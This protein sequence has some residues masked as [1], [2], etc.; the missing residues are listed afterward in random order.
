MNAAALELP[1]GLQNLVESRLDAIERALLQGNTP[2]AERRSILDDIETQI[3]EMLSAEAQGHEP[4]RADLLRV[5][6]RLDPPE[7]FAGEHIESARFAQTIR[8]SAP[9]VSIARS[10]SRTGYSAMGYSATGILACVGGL[11]T[12]T[13]G[14]PLCAFSM[15][16]S[17]SEITVVV[18]G[19]FL[20]LTGMPSMVLGI[21]YAIALH[22][23]QGRLRGLTCAAIGISAFP[24]S[25]IG[26]LGG[27]LAVQMESEI[28]ILGGGVI[29]CVL[30]VVGAIHLT[31]RSLELL[32]PRTEADVLGA[33][34]P[35]A[36]GR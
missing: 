23:S 36:E 30:A 27:F 18:F 21:L 8:R 35:A 32:I 10:T 22:Q 1:Q 11:A 19:G 3:I 24:I 2:R 12:L 17:E 34:G 13:L 33:N 6:T 25:V 28:F 7:A 16:L 4:T 14:L 29:L 31:Y 26:L 5:F 20:M 15:L 9:A